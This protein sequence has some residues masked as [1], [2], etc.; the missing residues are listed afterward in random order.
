[1]IDSVLSF[2]AIQPQIQTFGAPDSPLCTK[3]MQFG[4]RN[5]IIVVESNLKSE[6]DHRFRSNSKSNDGFE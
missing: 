5:Q 4:V 1:M 6:F 2:D 3:V